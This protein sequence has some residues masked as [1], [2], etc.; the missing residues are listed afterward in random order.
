MNG[1][2]IN[3]N[4]QLLKEWTAMTTFRSRAAANGGGKGEECN[5]IT[6]PKIRPNDG[7]EIIITTLMTKESMV[8]DIHRVTTILLH[9]K[10]KRKTRRKR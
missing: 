2:L 8:R 4:E 5:D 10:G 3:V 9:S 1:Q 6:Y 7:C